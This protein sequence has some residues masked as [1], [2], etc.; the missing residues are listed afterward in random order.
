MEM[1]GGA[2]GTKEEIQST[3]WG[4]SS[5]LHPH[6]PSL[7][8]DKSQSLSQSDSSFV[9]EMLPRQLQH[10]TQLCTVVSICD[11]VFCF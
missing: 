6:I 9:K 11:T 10:C 7:Y 3:G 5:L 1:K 2:E 4:S 8:T